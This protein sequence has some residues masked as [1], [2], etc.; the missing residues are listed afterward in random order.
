MKN[1][2]IITI[3]RQIFELKYQQ[4]LQLEKDLKEIDKIVKMLEEE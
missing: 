2:E 4:K 3:L 1:K